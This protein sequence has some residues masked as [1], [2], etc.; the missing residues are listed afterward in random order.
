[1]FIAPNQVW[2]GWVMIAVAVIGLILLAL[3]HFR[4]TKSSAQLIGAIYA[5][6]TVVS[7]SRW[8]KRLRKRPDEI[9]FR[10]M[11][12][13]YHTNEENIKARLESQLDRE[14]HDKLRAGELTAYGRTNHGNP[15]RPIPKEEWDEIEIMFDKESLAKCSKNAC[16]WLRDRRLV[17]GGRIRYIE[18][19]F[20]KTEIRKLF[21]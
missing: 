20:Q 1:M 7:K 12:E 21:R 6:N 5:F 8:A 4:I 14:I 17:S 3:Y 16:A 18:V 2:I 13:G 19:Q 15:L 9:K 11:Y 10:G